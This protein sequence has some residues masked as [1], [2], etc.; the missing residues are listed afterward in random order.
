MTPVPG[1]LTLSSELC[2]YH[3]YT[4]T[5]IL[6]KQGTDERR[7]RQRIPC[8]GFTTECLVWFGLVWFGLVWFGLVWF[9]LVWFGLVWF[10]LKKIS[11]S[12]HT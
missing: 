5:H 4:H 8:T 10:G 11:S 9:G 12:P 3:S 1:N 7:V 6:N 2:R